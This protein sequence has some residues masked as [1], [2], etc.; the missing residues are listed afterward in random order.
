MTTD[1]DPLVPRPIDQPTTLPL[2]GDIDAE[3]ADRARIFAA[4]D[5]P[6]D[7]PAWRAQLQRWR[8]DAVGRFGEIQYPV[9]TDWASRCFTVAIVWLWDE[10]LFDPEAQRFTPE[11]FF[12]AT[13]E[14]G[15]FDGI[16]LWHAYPI[17]GI[18]ERNQFDYYRAVPGLDTLV[19]ALHRRGLRVFIDYNPWDVGTRRE[20]QSDAAMLASL[21]TDLGVDGVFLDTMREGGHDLVETLRC[22][23]PPP[24]L[25]GE[26]RV[27]L[28]RIADHQMSWAQWFADTTA[29]GV[30]AA[31]WFE[32]SHMLHH[33]RRW[34]RD[35]SD[36]LQSSWMNGTGM[37]VWDAVFGSWVGWNDRD[38]STLRRLS[39]CQ[40]ALAEVLR[41]GE[42]TPQTDA[43]TAAIAAGVYASRFEHDNVTLWTLVNRGDGDFHG[44]VLDSDRA[45]G[46]WFDLHRG[47]QLS[48]PDDAVTVPARGIGGVLQVAGR[49]PGQVR[50][51]LEAQR[52]DPPAT[53]AAFPELVTTRVPPPRSTAAPPPD[54]IVLAAG[55]H[56][57]TV[58]YRLREPGM[59]GGAPFVEEWK[60]L[61]PRLHAEAAE[62]HTVEI[63][64]IAVATV[65]VLGPG[66]TPLTGV[67][68]AE[69]REHAA[70]VGARLPTEFEWQLAAADPAFRRAE[71]LVWNW[72]ESEH[73]DGITRFAIIKGGCAFEAVGSEWYF[74]GGPRPPEFSAKLLLAGLG[75]DRSPSIGLRLAWDL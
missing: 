67:S 57:L 23:D 69:A 34:N 26:S 45:G 10:R 31:H 65:E 25:E 52:D 38:R 24:V 53:D 17:I 50:S 33:T 27:P 73:S 15:G 49:V 40:M 13:A 46:A 61:P 4:P 55:R 28:E 14:F 74:D 41:H 16:V 3:I 51:M 44:V 32:R 9:A 19:G 71:P 42:W 11:R 43:A 66:G 70:S 59:Y 12:D 68:L 62:E 47:A 72:T 2:D 36:E 8:A 6:A 64:S 21:V 58:T 29:P 30:L 18:D 63:G 1:L 22:L 39:R 56:S 35:H 37:I 20:A 60:P 75:T 54:A 7:W 5:D 48:G